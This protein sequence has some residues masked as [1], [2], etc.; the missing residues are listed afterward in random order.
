ME[1]YGAKVVARQVKKTVDHCFP[2]AARSLLVFHR[3][4]SGIVRTN[5]VTK[6]LYSIANAIALSTIFIECCSR[7]KYPY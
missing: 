6:T 3:Q 1:H 4:R 5:T 2:G 7:A